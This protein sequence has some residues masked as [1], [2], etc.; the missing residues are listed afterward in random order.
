M[1][2]HGSKFESQNQGLD[3]QTMQRN[4]VKANRQDEITKKKKNK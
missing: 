2:C 4:H 1:I 3:Q